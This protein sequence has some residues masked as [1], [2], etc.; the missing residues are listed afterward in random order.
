MFLR[1]CYAMSGTDLRYAPTRLSTARS[2]LSP[3]SRLSTRVVPAPILYAVSGI[4]LRHVRYPSA[5][6]PV[7]SYAISGSMGLVLVTV[8]L[9]HVRYPPTPCP[10]VT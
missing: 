9:R 7:S 8:L 2:C 3:P 10:V 5:P 6:C 1:I 4:L